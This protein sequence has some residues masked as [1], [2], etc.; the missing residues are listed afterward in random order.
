MKSKQISA[1]ILLYR[2][3]DELEVL[4]V[5]PGGPY[6]K[7]KDKGAWSIPKGVVEPGEDIF[8]TALRELEEETHIIPFDNND[9]LSLGHIT[10]KGGKVVHAW[11]CRSGCDISAISS[12]TC[13][14]EWPPKSGNT[15]SV[16]EVD[17]AEFFTIDE[18]M[19]KINVAQREFLSRLVS[20][21]EQ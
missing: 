16:P 5:H 15:I 4:L 20:H 12:N 21:L 2:I 8:S 14:I 6:W 18:A 19:L 10:Q 3:R 11:A 9:T 7:N 1:G 17:R 13:E